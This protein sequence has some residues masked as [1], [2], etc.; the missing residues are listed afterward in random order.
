[1][2]VRTSTHAYLAAEAAKSGISIT[3]AAGVILEHACREGWTIGP[4]VVT[5][6]PAVVTRLGDERDEGP[7]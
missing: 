4:V 7:E 3:Q 5:R 1:M 6:P 2:R